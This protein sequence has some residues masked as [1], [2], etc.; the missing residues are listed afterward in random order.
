M[1]NPMA[2]NLRNM[3]AYSRQTRTHRLQNS[4][5]QLSDTILGHPQRRNTLRVR[6][7]HQDG[8]RERQATILLVPAV[9]PRS[10]KRDNEKEEG[11]NGKNESTKTSNNYRNPQE[12]R[13]SNSKGEVKMAYNP[14]RIYAEIEAVEIDKEG[15][16][17][18]RLHKTNARSGIDAGHELL[19]LL[20]QNVTLSVERMRN[21]RYGSG[22]KE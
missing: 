1:E 15:N 17:I 14:L 13:P 21:D 4:S 6:G 9:V 2:G 19:E 20:G 5:T 10:D 8:G 7:L 11:R 22:E 3:W 12:V 18:M 16:V